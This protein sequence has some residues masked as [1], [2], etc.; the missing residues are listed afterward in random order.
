MLPNDTMAWGY[1][2]SAIRELMEYGAARKAEIGAENVYDF[3][4]GN[5]SIPAP[6]CVNEAIAQLAGGDSLALHSYTTAAGL[7]SL[8]RKIADDLNSRFSLG[9]TEGELYV[10]CGAA[11]SLA[12]S[13]KATL[14]PGDEVLVMVP[15][16]PEYRVFIEAAGGVVRTVAP[17]EDLMIDFDALQLALSERTKAVIINSPNN[18]SGVIYSEETI[19]KLADMLRVQA[20]KNGQPI[21]LLSDEPYRELVYDGES[22][23][24]ALNYY[25]DSI[26][27]YSFSKSMSIPGERLGYIA[28]NP[29][30]A[31]KDDVYASILGAA[32][33]LGYVNPPSLF[34]RVIEQCIGSYTDVSEYRQNRDLLCA[35]LAE[36]GYEF[37]R[38]QG[39]FYLF[40]KALEPDANAFS[41]KAKQHDLLLVP[42]DSFGCT[43]YVRV[44]YCVSADMIKRSMPAFKALMAEY[45]K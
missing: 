36:L 26:M 20:E 30:I 34:Q 27:C 39:A 22:V 32:R 44:A 24:C 16:F 40:V 2:R 19:R 43:G 5:P 18:P 29:K 35:G 45:K 10:T 12:I 28:L 37:V 14:L 23:P 25:D 33:A 9:I 38:P 3:S 41:E 31:D 6:D 15:F 21:Y 17:D 4:I 1:T 8:R 11:A 13:L 7:P 42:S